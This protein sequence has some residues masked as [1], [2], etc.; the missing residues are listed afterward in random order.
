MCQILGYTREELLAMKGFDL[1]DADSRAFFAERIR[2]AQSGDKPE[3]AVE[4]RVR[5]KDGRLICALVSAT[6]RWSG[7]TITGATVVAHDIS[8]RKRAEQ[9]VQDQKEQLQAQNEELAAQQGE[10]IEARDELEVRVQERTAELEDANAA[11]EEEIEERTRAEDE[12]RRLNE[13]LQ[14]ALRQE[15]AMHQQLVQAEKLGALGRMVSSVAHELNN[16]LQTIRNCLYL[17]GADLPPDSPIHQYLAMASSETQRLVNLVAQLR[18]LYRLRTVA[19]ETHD[20]VPLLDNVRA[21]M[22]AQLESGRVQWQQPAEL[23]PYPVRMVADRLKQ[24]FINVATN[25]IE[26]MQPAG[27]QLE[28]NATLSADGTQVGVGFKDCG[29]GIPPRISTACSSPSSPPSRRGWDWGCPSAM[30]SPSSMA[31]ASRSRASPARA[32]CSPFGCRSPSRPRAGP[33]SSPPETSPMTASR[34]RLLIA[35]DEPTYV[36]SLTMILPAKGSVSG[37]ALNIQDL[38]AAVGGQAGDNCKAI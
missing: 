7:K 9:L 26:A 16:P 27:G 2:R 34:P 32:P 18:E 25:A 29:P 22:T 6:F 13:D 8:E 19:P 31:A 28:V 12:I 20:L 30:R 5:T 36:R 3:E 35:H 17:T 4:Y 11:L 14:Q 1:M 15:Q 21:L 37:P 23:P 24:V 33:A 10:L 38:P